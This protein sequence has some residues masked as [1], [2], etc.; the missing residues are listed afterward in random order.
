[1]IG[2]ALG[3]FLARTPW[4]TFMAFLGVALGVV[5]I[6][7]VHLISTTIATRLDT[8]IPQQLV[9]YSHFL[10]RE[11]LHTDAYFALRQ[12]WRH[13]QH[14][15]IIHLAPLIDEIH[16]LDGENIRVIGIDLFSVRGDFPNSAQPA[17]KHEFSWS[18]VWVDETL[19]KK[20]DKLAL[21]GLPLNGV[22]AGPPGVLLADIGTA[23]GI[24]GWPSTRISYVGL[25]IRSSLAAWVQVA[26]H[27]LPGFSAGFTASKTKLPN[28]DQWQ[29]LSLADQHPA[30]QFGKSILFNISALGLLAL[31]VA[32]FLIYQVAV[33]WLRRLWPVLQRLH[34]IG[35]EWRTLGAFFVAALS[36]LGLVA[37]MV[38]LALGYWLAYFLFNEMTQLGNPEL[39]LD[40]WVILKALISSVG[41]CMVGGLWAIRQSRAK[42]LRK[43]N[44]Y[45]L[46]TLAALIVG[47]VFV[48]RT[49]LAGGFLSIALLSIFT[50]LVVTPVLS[51]LRRYAGLIAGPYLLRLSLRESFW[52]PQDMSVALSGLTLAVATAIGVGLMVDSFR[53]DFSSML[54]RRLSYD[55]VVRGEDKALQVLHKTLSAASLEQNGNVHRVQKYS[56]LGLRIDGIPMMLIQTR[57]DLEESR[58]YG[59]EK[60]LGSAQM[61]ISEQAGRL[62]GVDVED[63]LLLNDKHFE[64]VGVFSSFGDMTP[65]L[66]VDDGAVYENADNPI[67]GLSLSM[68]DPAEGMSRLAI[69]FP[70]LEFVLQTQLRRTALAAFDQTFS[71]TTVLIFIAMLVASLGVYVAVNAL[72]LNKQTNGR[73]LESM[74]ISRLEVHGM[75][76]AL[77]IGIG[78]VAMLFAIPLGLSF[79]WILCSVINPRAFGWT[80][81]PQF[82]ASAV[83]VPVA[84]GVAAAAVAGLVRVGRGEDEVSHASR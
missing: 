16:R 68:H 53:A 41:V 59:Y 17:L 24:L 46:L 33:S 57:M 19:F 36:V 3:R 65:K 74:G 44:I 84:L 79:G 7:S 58:R 55:I 39:D 40:L 83:F 37:G 50:A 35:V 21:L 43:A 15:D 8:L 14:P 76:L 47:G 49:G 20:G 29:L 75:D 71:I 28:L 82:S 51:A 45:L 56:E 12:Q 32:W 54:D 78:V 13:G 10:H 66:I 72:R 27:L 77:G 2:L 67:S 11:N 61:L 30:S 64:V 63:A 38:G 31:L 1:M 26:E 70:E 52:Y 6:V 18:G 69:R 81:V 34:V 42:L 23:Q 48:P 80:V 4:S 73:L 25:E 60:M 62:L 9:G 5:S 22:I